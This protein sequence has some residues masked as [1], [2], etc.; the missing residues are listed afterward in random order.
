[1]DDFEESTP[2]WATKEFCKDKNG[3]KPTDENYDPSTLFIPKGEIE[4]FTP[5][6]Q[7]EIIYLFF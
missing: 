6:M 2:K 7:V 3:R 4:K 5:A 1:M